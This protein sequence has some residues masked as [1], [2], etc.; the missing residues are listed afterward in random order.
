MRIR[1]GYDTDAMRN[2]TIYDLRY[3]YG[4]NTVRQ[5]YD[6][7]VRDNHGSLPPDRVREPIKFN[8]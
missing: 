1:Y 7:L 5:R 8:L 3:G 2:D 4:T 6:T